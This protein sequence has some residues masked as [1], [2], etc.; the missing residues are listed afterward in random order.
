VDASVDNETTSPEHLLGVVTKSNYSEDKVKKNFHF[1]NSVQAA[2]VIRG[3]GIRGFD[4][5]RKKKPR[6]TRENC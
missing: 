5:S 6:I 2:L 1:K 3:F 4:Y